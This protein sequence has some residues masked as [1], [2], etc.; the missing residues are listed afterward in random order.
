MRG[1]GLYKENVK[2]VRG[3]ENAR[4]RIRRQCGGDNEEERM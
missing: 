3:E 4:K 2:M 1:E